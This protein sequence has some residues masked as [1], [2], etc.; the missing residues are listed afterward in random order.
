MNWSVIMLLYIIYKLPVEIY[1][2]ISLKVES[3]SPNITR[4]NLIY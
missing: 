4:Y 1:M 3:Y 2:L